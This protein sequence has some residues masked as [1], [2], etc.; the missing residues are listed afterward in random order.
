MRKLGFQVRFVRPKEGGGWDVHIKGFD[1]SRT[2]GAY[3]GAVS[4]ATQKMGGMRLPGATMDGNDEDAPTGNPEGPDSGGDGNDE[5]A[6]TGNPEGPDSGGDGGGEDAPCGPSDDGDLSSRWNMTSLSA[7]KSV[8]CNAILNT[9]IS[10][11]GL[12]VIN[13]ESF[14]QA[15]F[16]VSLGD[17][18]CGMFSCRGH[19]LDNRSLPAANNARAR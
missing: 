14:G 15:G 5:D 2:A 16:A 12:V 3:K 18:L 8:T 1:P 10:E 6:P 17:E 9:S 19:G 4:T 11:A 7:T 13:Q